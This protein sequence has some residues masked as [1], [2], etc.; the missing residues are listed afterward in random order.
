MPSVRHRP[1]SNPVSKFIIIVPSKKSDLIGNSRSD[2][3]RNEKFLHYLFIMKIVHEVHSK[4][5]HSS[6]IQ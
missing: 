5:K 1:V 6:S 2:L 4:P 3:Y